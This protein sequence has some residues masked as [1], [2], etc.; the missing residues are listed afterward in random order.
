MDG[1]KTTRNAGQIPMRYKAV[2]IAIA[3]ATLLAVWLVPDDRPSTPPPLPELPA[4][5]MTDADLFQPVEGDPAAIRHG[6]RARGFIASLRSDGTEPDP[7]IVFVEAMRLQGE[8]YAVDAHLLYRFAAR[9]G[10][11]QAALVLGNQADPA[12]RDA[13]IPDTLK[14]QPEQAYKW[15]SIAAE[16]GI[17][18]ATV[19]LQALRKRMEQSA[20]NGDE[21]AQRLL[22]LWN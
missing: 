21:R 15:Y 1:K 6:D 14:D 13:D 7:D 3:V 19:Q 11:G 18:E 10:H 8:G 12:F 9:H 20:A 22:L 17:D 2:M 4:P 16:E 5:R